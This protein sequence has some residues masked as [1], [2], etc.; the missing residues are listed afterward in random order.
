MKRFT[1]A[2]LGDRSDAAWEVDRWEQ[3]EN[4]NRNHKRVSAASLGI[5][6]LAVAGM[7]T[8]SQMKQVVFVPIVT[9]RITGETTVG[10]ALREDT[11]PALDA[12][13]KKCAGDF[14]RAREG[15]SWAFLKRDYDAVARLASPEVFAPFQ[16]LYYPQIGKG[17][18]QAWA[19]GQEHVI[20]IVSRRLTG[21][22]VGGGKG[23]VVTYD[24]ASTYHDKSRHDAITRH[25][26]TLTYDYHPKMLQKEE[27]RAENP[28]GCVITAY[29]SDP[30]GDTQG[31]A[32]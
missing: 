1:E 22:A 15:Y 17:R 24:K 31:A 18:Q 9:D 13:D 2:L 21:A 4:S 6:A 29:R 27:D 5:A 25:V 7:V 12:L 23:M 16:A 11:V 26:A 30:V 10:Q 3:M 20:T 28:Y 19:K 32:P 14:V 8:L